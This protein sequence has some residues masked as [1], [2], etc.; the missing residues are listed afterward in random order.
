MNANLAHSIRDWHLWYYLIWTTDNTLGNSCFR[1]MY[2][3]ATGSPAMLRMPIC[4]QSAPRPC[5]CEF[6]I[7]DMAFVIFRR[8][9]SSPLVGSSVLL[10][11]FI[12][13]DRPA[14]WIYQPLHKKEEYYGINSEKTVPFCKSGQAFQPPGHKKAASGSDPDAAVLSWHAGNYQSFFFS[15]K[16]DNCSSLP[17]WAQ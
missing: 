2:S 9:S 6:S 4:L 7:C 1:R 14:R 15:L 12:Y 8:T 13:I 10:E 5:L 16:S 3:L 11:A 17:Q